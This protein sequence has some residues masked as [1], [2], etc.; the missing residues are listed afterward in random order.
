M[1]IESYLHAFHVYVVVQLHTDAQLLGPHLNWLGDVWQR[2]NGQV[3]LA[4]IVYG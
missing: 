2:T 4:L 3:L 1:S